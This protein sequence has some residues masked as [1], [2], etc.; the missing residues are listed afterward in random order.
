MQIPFFDL[1]RLH[2]PYQGDLQKKISDVIATGWYVR[3]PY[4]ADFEKAFAQYLNISQVVGVGNGLDALTLIFRAYMALGKLEVGDEIIVPA[5]TY[6]A[7]VLAISECGLVPVL[8]EPDL[9]SYNIDV[10]KVKENI[11]AKTKAVL[12]VN[13]YGLVSDVEAL[14]FICKERNL[15]LIE[16]NAQAAGATLEKKHAGTFGDAAGFSFY[17]TKNLGALGDGG[18]VVTNDEKLAAVV[19]AIANYG[20]EEKYKNIYKGVNSRLDEIQAAALLVKLQHLDEENDRRRS[21]AE[22][23]LGGIDNPKIALPEGEYVE[24]HVWHLFVVRTQNRESFMSYLKEQGI[25]T[26]IHYPTPIYQHPAYRDMAFLSRPI[27]E[28]ICDEVLS[29]PMGPYLTVEEVAY[30]VDVVNGY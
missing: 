30:V 17:P 23:Y 27:T 15:L 13:L 14:Q 11:N 6:I 22:R 26:Q 16:D 18:A 25:Q 29:L 28:K 12:T 3:G 7:S 20:S 10:L 21:V 5:N 9:E 8:V 19:R 24:N 4:V 2:Q 1:K